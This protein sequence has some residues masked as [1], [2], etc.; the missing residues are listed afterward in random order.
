VL[1]VTA[2]RSDVRDVAR[3][4]APVRTVAPSHHGYT[5]PIPAL[6]REQLADRA[7]IERLKAEISAR[8]AALASRPAPRVVDPVASS[9]GRA[10]AGFRR[11]DKLAAK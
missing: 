1:D 11:R 7:E 10:L 9:A 2:R 4:V 5:A 3:S 8:K 6:T